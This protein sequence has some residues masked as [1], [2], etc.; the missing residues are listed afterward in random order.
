MKELA[1][2]L[3]ELA[4]QIVAG[5]PFDENDLK[6]IWISNF[7][8]GLILEAAKVLMCA[9]QIEEYEEIKKHMEG[10]EEQND[11]LENGVPGEVCG[12]GPDR[13]EATD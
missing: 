13:Q 3:Q 2:K 1:M 12:N 10:G 11:T 7:D 8:L 4:A 6:D 5:E 9:A